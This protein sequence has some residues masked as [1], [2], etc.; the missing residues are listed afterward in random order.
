MRYVYEYAIT[1]DTGCFKGCIKLLD[2]GN[3]YLCDDMM[4]MITS[5]HSYLCASI[6]VA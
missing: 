3:N 5:L 1:S 2:R 4:I 6:K